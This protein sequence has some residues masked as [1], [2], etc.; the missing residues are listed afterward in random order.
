[1]LLS[2]TILVQPPNSAC[3]PQQSLSNTECP[4]SMWRRK[5]KVKSIPRSYEEYRSK[6]SHRD[7]Y[8]FFFCGTNGSFSKP[9]S[10]E[11]NLYFNLGTRWKVAFWTSCGMKKLSKKQTVWWFWMAFLP[12]L[13][14]CFPCVCKSWTGVI[15]RIPIFVEEGRWAERLFM[16]LLSS[17]LWSTSSFGVI[18]ILPTWHISFLS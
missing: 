1:M 15:R 18:L 6:I 11:Q 4:V 7:L 8:G 9:E 13:A 5:C 17:P 10:R 12:C 3:F 16:L 14:L 2:L